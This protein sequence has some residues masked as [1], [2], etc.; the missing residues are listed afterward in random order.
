MKEKNGS[1]NE[2]NEI[3]IEWS[4]KQWMEKSNFHSYADDSHH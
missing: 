4:N 3:R 1:E 2:Q